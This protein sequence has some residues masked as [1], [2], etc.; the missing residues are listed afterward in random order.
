MRKCVAWVLW[1]LTANAFAQDLD[2]LL[3]DAARYRQQ[4]NLTVAIDLLEKAK[5]AAGPSSEPRLAGEL[6]A[7]YF[8]ARRFAEAE[9]NLIDAYNRSTNNFERAIFANDLGNIYLARGRAEDAARFYE[10]ARSRSAGIPGIKLSAELNLAR[11]NPVGERL[12]KLRALALAIE[13]MTDQEARARYLLNLGSQARQLGGGATKLAFES[14]DQ[15]RSLAL[16]SRDRLVLAEA[17]DNLAQLYE[18]QNRLVDA[19]TLSDQAIGVL[20][21]EAASELLINL[22]WRRGRLLN[23]NGA[24]RDA[25]LA[26]QAA[27]DQ[28]EAIRQD[29]PVEYVDGRSSFRE[30]LEPIYLGLADLLLREGRSASTKASTQLF[31]RARDT[32]ELIKQ[33]ELQDYLG[34]RCS[35]EGVIGSTSSNVA[36]RTAVLYP[37]ILADRLELMLETRQGISTHSVAVTRKDLREKALAFARSVRFAKLDYLVRAR[38]LYDLLLR[39]FEAELAQQGITKLVIIPDGVLRLIPLSALHDGEQFVV[40]RFAVA[41]APGLSLTNTAQ[42]QRAI[43]K[44]LLA[45]LSEPGPVVERMPK[46][47]ADEFIGE[48]TPDDVRSAELRGKLALPSV[49]EEIQALKGKIKGDAMLN[50]E[51]TVERFKRQVSTGEYRIVH[52]ASHAIFSRRAETSYIMA[53]DDILTTDD[54]QKILRAQQLEANP[55]E[56]LT[57][58]AC[59]T[60]EG[61]DRAPLGIAGAAL[62]ARAKSALGSLWP[63]SDEATMKLMIEF[64]GYLSSGESKIESLRQAQLRMLKLPQLQHPFF[65]APF[66]LVGNWM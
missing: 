8:Q 65:W 63:V 49:K 62:K 47:L 32:V 51:F 11:L 30:T 29:I 46:P 23:A 6:G 41:T 3:K 48:E 57:L 39:P 2:A 54:L 20:K 44:V 14:L 10:E 43:G 38:E 61:D 4:G 64:Y 24:A 1:I 34:D 12:E 28:I 50:G 13:E 7:A 60:A 18:D 55:I 42:P 33:S 19:M 5:R 21:S 37:V 26:Y 59:Q 36:E 25:L 9:T 22:H 27:V 52:V 15:A 31:R 58:S 16:G 53:Y 17:L 66:V 56:M 35:T 40:E 45:G